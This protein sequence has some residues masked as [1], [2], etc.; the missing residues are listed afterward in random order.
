MRPAEFYM[1]SP[2][3]VTSDMLSPQLP[4]EPTEI[5]DAFVSTSAP[6]RDVFRQVYGAAVQISAHS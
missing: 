6:N 2:G 3:W 1:L 4:I 5:S